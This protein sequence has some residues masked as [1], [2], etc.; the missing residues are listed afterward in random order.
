MITH[1]APQRLKGFSLLEV[2]IT[3]FVVAVGLLSVAGLQAISK[4]SNFD[5]VQ[6]TVAAALA[7]DLIERIRA[8]SS[9]G[10]VYVSK[11]GSGISESSNTPAAPGVDCNTGV[12]GT[13]VC[14]PA[15]V[16]DFDLYQWTQ[17]LFGRA[18]SVTTGTGPSASTEYTGGLSSATACIANATAPCGTY[19]VTIVWRGITPLPIAASNEAGTA[20]ATSCGTG[21]PAYDTAPVDSTKTLRR[22]IQ[23]Q[24]VIDDHNGTCTAS[25]PAATR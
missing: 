11:A 4:K 8:N 9:Q 1:R 20:I 15:Q 13:S 18:E 5:S 2:M 10:A 6:R 7:Q 12:V 23:M 25:Q 24:T 14:T 22:V 3:V 16:V 19:T 21:N 17:A